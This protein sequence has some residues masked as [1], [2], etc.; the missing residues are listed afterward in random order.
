MALTALSQII[1]LPER[2]QLSEI[3]GVMVEVYEMGKHNDKNK[4]NFTMK[5]YSGV[6]VR[7]TAWSHDDI[8]FYKGKEVIIKAG[9][10]GGLAVNNYRDKAGVSVSATCSFQTVAGGLAPQAPIPANSSPSAAPANTNTAPHVRPVVQGQTI[11]MAINNACQSL[12]AQGIPLT[13]G[14]VWKLASMVVAVAQAMEQGKL[15]EEAA[16]APKVA[17]PAPEPD[18]AGPDDRENVPFF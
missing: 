11:G 13:K 4:Q 6:L 17:A 18:P 16:P 9:P 10:K 8:S 12:T 14:N 1:N 7:G 5:D 15:F 3:Q 2:C